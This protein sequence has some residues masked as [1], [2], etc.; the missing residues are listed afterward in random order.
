MKSLAF[1]E[2]VDHDRKMRNFAYHEGLG[3]CRETFSR[4]L[5]GV[6]PGEIGVVIT[7]DAACLSI[8]TSPGWMEAFI[9]AVKQHQV[10]IGDHGHDLVY[11]LRDEEDEAQFRALFSPGEYERARRAPRPLGDA[12][13]QSPFAA[14]TIERGENWFLVTRFEGKDAPTYSLSSGAIGQDMDMLMLGHWKELLDLLTPYGITEEEGWC[15]V[16][17]ERKDWLSRTQQQEDAMAAQS[18]DAMEPHRGSLPKGAHV[19]VILPGSGHAR[20]KQRR[21]RG[22]RSQ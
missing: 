9:Q 12:I 16:P 8:E 21:K 14:A 22:G 17:P 13:A 11:D 10:L 7:P 18:A 3:E 1:L 4:L 5:Q 20:G 15:P 2:H 6:Q 19:S